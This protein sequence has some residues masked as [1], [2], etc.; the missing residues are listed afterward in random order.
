MLQ[1]WG[2]RFFF[3][4]DKFPQRR[5]YT[6]GRVCNVAAAFFCSSSLKLL[7]KNN[8]GRFADTGDLKRNIAPYRL[9]APLGR[10]LD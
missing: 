5:S 10:A 1:F 6:L 3:Q 2:N 7:G 9:L 8:R 4:P